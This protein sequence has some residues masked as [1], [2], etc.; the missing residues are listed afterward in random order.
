MSINL[1]TGATG[2]LG[3]HTCLHLLNSGKKVVGVSRN[4]AARENTLKIFSYYGKQDLLK[5]IEWREADILDTEQLFLAFDNVHTVYHCAALVSF[6][7]GEE[8]KLASVNREGTANVVNVCLAKKVNKLCYVSSVAALG[9]GQ[10]KPTDETFVF[11]FSSEKTAYGRSKF[12]GEMEVWRGIEEGLNAVIVNPSIILGPGNWNNGSPQLFTKAHQGMLFSSPGSTGFVDVRDVAKIM[13]Q[14]TESNISG[15]R[16]LVNGFHLSYSTFFQ[17]VCDALGSRAPKIIAPRIAGELMW[18]WESL[19]WKLSGRTPLLTR[20]TVNTA[21]RNQE[22]DTKKI[23]G[24][25]DYSFIPSEDSIRF[26][27]QKFLEDKKSK[28]A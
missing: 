1:V 28:T 3:A 12:E 27:A 21:Y 2:L 9:R 13:V 7:K 23:L 19:L 26:I 5:K 16:F 17:M 18:R 10:E 14:L 25:L 20:E 11:D 15:E 8:K 22:Y 24:M 4:E 6:R